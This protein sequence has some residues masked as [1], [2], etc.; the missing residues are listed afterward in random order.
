M[1]AMT[2]PTLEE[3]RQRLID[4]MALDAKHHAGWLEI[5]EQKLVAAR[6]REN[7]FKRMWDVSTVGGRMLMAREVCGMSREQAAIR[8]GTSASMY[9]RW[10]RG[11]ANIP[12]MRFRTVCLVLGVR[13]RW[14]LGETEEGGPPVPKEQLRRRVTR[15][16]KER[17][18]YLAARA[19]A[20]KELAA[21]NGQYRA[22]KR[23]RAE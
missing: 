12:A 19:K 17:Q 13:E 7:P 22:N 16:W 14:L 3:A 10:E 8:I 15:R 6:A 18:D 1:T 5:A 20:R 9:G 21:L 11:K 23:R 4:A 2:T